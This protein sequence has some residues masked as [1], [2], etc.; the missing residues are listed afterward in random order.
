MKKKIIIT[1]LL[2]F[3]AI[4]MVL[5][6]RAR[7]QT[8]ADSLRADSIYKSMELQGVEIVKQKSLVKSDIDKITYDIE[9][10]PD[11]KSN[12]V[13]EMLR[14]VPMVTVDGEDNI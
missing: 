12:T 10:D 6:L 14:K 3:V 13:I 11:S 1:A 4:L 5:P 7:A 2:A 8:K 9:N